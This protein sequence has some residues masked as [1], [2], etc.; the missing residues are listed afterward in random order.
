MPDADKE[1]SKEIYHTLP[2]GKKIQYIF[3]YYKIIL[4]LIAAGIGVFVYIIVRTLHPDPETILEVALVE[5][6]T[7]MGD[8]ADVFDR[9]LAAVR[10]RVR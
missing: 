3:Q 2:V 10:T 6:A 4:V 1:R 8:E 5:A 7:P 9:F